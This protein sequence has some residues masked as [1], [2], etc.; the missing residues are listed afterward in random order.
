MLARMT[1]AEDSGTPEAQIHAEIRRAIGSHQLPPGT[2]L[3]EDEMR[4]LFSVS[5]NR[6]RAVFA[7]LEQDGLVEIAPNRGASVARPTAQDARDLFAARRGVEAAILAGL[8]L[9]LPRRARDRLAAHVEAERRAHAARDRPAMVSLSG[10]FHLTLAEIAGNRLLE[11][12]L[13]ELILRESLVIQVHERP[14]V[15]SCSLSEHEA[16]L[17][18]LAAGD[19]AVA[20][21]RMAEHLGEIEGRLDLDR[22]ARPPLSLETVFAGRAS[23]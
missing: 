13:A 6:I 17:A 16:V 7:R 22:D 9:P 18:A 2:R 12:F 4:R 10:E 5:R 1:V 23:K 15:P 19:L 11:K 20:Q 3:R 8:P 21:A 14:G